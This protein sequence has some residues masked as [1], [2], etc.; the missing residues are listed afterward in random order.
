MKTEKIESC[1]KFRTTGTFLHFRWE[2]KMREWQKIF[3]SFLK[4][5]HVY[6][7]NPLIPLLGIYHKE[8]NIC[9]CAKTSTWVHII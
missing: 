5:K 9:V 8:I 4:V 6:H 3:Y 7:Y 1:W 2:C